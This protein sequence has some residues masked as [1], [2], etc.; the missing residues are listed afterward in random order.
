MLTNRIKRLENKL[1]INIT[2]EDIIRLI[3]NKDLLT[4]NEQHR[5]ISSKLYQQMVFTGK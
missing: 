1:K 3:R 4:Q 5:I 2:I